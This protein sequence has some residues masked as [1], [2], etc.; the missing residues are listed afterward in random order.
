MMRTAAPGQM[1]YLAGYHIQF[2]GLLL[3]TPPGDAVDAPGRLPVQDIPAWSAY[4][5]D[6]VKKAGGRIQYWEVWNEP[7]NF[8]GRDQTPADYAKIVVSAYDAAHGIDPGCKVGL[9]A[10]SVDVNYLERAIQ[11][12]A[13]DHF[14]FVVLHPYEAL[15]AVADCAG[16]EPGFLNI[17]PAVRKMLAAQDP[18]RENVPIIFTEI[19]CDARKGEDTQAQALVKAYT[20][21]I[22]QGVECIEW[23]E[24]MDGDSGPMGLLDAKGR[25]RPAYTA[26]AQMIQYLGERPEYLGRNPHDPCS[27]CFRGAGGR[28]VWIEWARRDA[29]FRVQSGRAL[30]FVDPITGKNEQTAARDVTSSSVL[31]LGMGADGAVKVPLGFGGDY[32]EAKSVSLIQGAPDGGHGLRALSRTA[33]YVDPAFLTYTPE[34]I[35]IRVTVRRDDPA[36]NAGFKLRYESTS[37]FKN[38]GWYTVP[39]DGQW[40]TMSWKID[41]DEF[42][43]M[44]AYEFCLDSDGDQYDK[45]S[46]RDVTVTKRDSPAEIQ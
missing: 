6:W 46:I 38:S 12:G 22:A 41:D 34:P 1:D 21:G 31:I 42:V 28:I 14:D 29:P 5:A 11:A 3:G 44:W 9:A 10:K 36:R 30:D 2:G 37:G 20:L 4:V 13:K 32:S 16:Y 17:V 43:G 23:F 15:D 19:G 27:F 35:E 26:M 39:G 40:H 25:A 8:T 45:Y 33:F 18:A 24:G 7:P